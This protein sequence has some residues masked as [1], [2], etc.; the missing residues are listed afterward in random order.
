MEIYCEL[1]LLIL[2]RGMNSGMVISKNRNN[3]MC[4]GSNDELLTA[5]SR[6]VEDYHRMEIYCE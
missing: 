2:V 6:V 5:N 1:K 3:L 4:Q